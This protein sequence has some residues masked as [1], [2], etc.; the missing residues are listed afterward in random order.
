MGGPHDVAGNVDEARA[1]PSPSVY[2]KKIASVALSLYLDVSR[3]L[4]GRH[5]HTLSFPLPNRKNPR[6]LST[7]FVI[8]LDY[9]ICIYSALLLCL[10]LR[11][12]S[13]LVVSP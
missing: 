8:R 7:R 13:P 4:S 3:A 9:P 2:V 10:F 12:Y 6:N 11:S 1:P 5:S